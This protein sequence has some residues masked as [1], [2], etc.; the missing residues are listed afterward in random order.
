MAKAEPWFHEMSVAYGRPNAPYR[1]SVQIFGSRNAWRWILDIRT[2]AEAKAA[3]NM[4]ETIAECLGQFGNAGFRRVIEA[5]S[6]ETFLIGAEVVSRA[7][8]A[9]AEL[10]PLPTDEDLGIKR[11]PDGVHCTCCSAVFSRSGDTEST[12]LC[13]SCRED[14]G[15]ATVAGSPGQG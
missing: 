7:N 9:G 4:P 2:R 10:L 8:K 6:S 13:E 1:P 5:D 12:G 3:P 15:P 14:H 11:V